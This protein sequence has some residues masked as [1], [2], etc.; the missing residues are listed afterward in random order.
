MALSS[1][2][3]KEIENIIRKEIKSFMGNSTIKQ[4]EDK[5]MDKIQKE[6]K[7][8]RL[9]SGVK[10]ITQKMFSEFYQLMWSNRTQLGQK[11]K[12]T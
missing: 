4:F 5:F 1:T 10:D 6:I 8:G 7:R 3:K 11:L 9:E 2:E 12:N